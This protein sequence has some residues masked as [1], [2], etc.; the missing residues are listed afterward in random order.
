MAWFFLRRR[1][2][3]SGREIQQQED[4]LFGQGQL[5]I[6]R[7]DLQHFMFRWEFDGDYSAPLRNPLAILDVACGTGRWA[8]EMARRFPNAAVFGFDNNREQIDHSIAEGV[9]RG[10]TL[11][12]NCT[13]LT[14]DALQPFEFPDGSFQ[15]V[16]AR[17]NS[18]YVPIDHW[19]TLLAEMIRVTAPQGWIEVRDFG[20][21]R[22]ESLA[23]TAMTGIFVNL[24]A[25]RGIHPG[26]GPYLQ[27]YFAPLP[28]REQHIKTVTVRGG[29]R[30]TRGGRMLLADYLA[31]MERVTPIVARAGL[32][33]AEQW[34][35]L[36]QQARQEVTH[37][38]TE[39]ELTAAYGR[40]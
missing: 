26:V 2:R 11:P 33:S 14:G 1:R 24:A 31:L 3:I 18:A 22:S 34:K 12:D 36:W 32:A 5:E 9:K 21:V 39:V 16:M 25:A 19:P 13:F 28:L 27:R 17:A 20:V 23:L 4:Y 37:C 15:F 7:L 10:E 35:Q 29:P 38:T 6:N 40:R 8:R 30:P